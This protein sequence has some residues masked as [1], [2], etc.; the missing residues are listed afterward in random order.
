MMI[1]LRKQWTLGASGCKERRKTREY[2]PASGSVWRVGSLNVTGKR[3][4]VGVAVSK[5]VSRVP[6]LIQ[7]CYCKTPKTV[8]SLGG[9]RD[10][11]ILRYDSAFLH[12]GEI[13]ERAI[14]AQT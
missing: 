10:Q 2:S 1:G 14:S 8:I 13:A 9:K 7:R 11:G 3:L 12:Y 6:T 5:K 4:P